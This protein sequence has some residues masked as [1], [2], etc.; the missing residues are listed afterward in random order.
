MK[1]RVAVIRL[2]NNLKQIE[3]FLNLLIDKK[4]LEENP[5]LI[6][7]R[8]ILKEQ[9][10]RKIYCFLLY[11][12]K[13]NYIKP[14]SLKFSINRNDEYYYELFKPEFF[15]LEDIPTL[16]GLEYFRQFLLKEYFENVDKKLNFIG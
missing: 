8:G 5:K 16:E 15:N 9:E 12:N 6:N 14:A 10:E 13:M 1:P 11:A 4:N 3:E 2:S 7:V